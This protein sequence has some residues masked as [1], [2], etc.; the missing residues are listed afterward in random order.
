[1]D[2]V[3][4]EDLLRRPFLV[5]HLSV[6]VSLSAVASFVADVFDCT[7][8]FE[9][10]FYGSAAR[11]HEGA[12]SMLATTRLGV[13]LSLAGWPRD[14]RAFY[15][16]A[17]DERDER[18]IDTFVGGLP[19]G[20][21]KHTWRSELARYTPPREEDEAWVY[22]LAGL[23]SS[24]PDVAPREDASRA[25]AAMLSARGFGAWYVPTES[26]L[27]AEPHPPSSR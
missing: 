26:E 2:R 12:Q 27:R 3:H 10:R 14:F 6:D 21:G 24:M 23:P 13:E 5:R 16:L 8:D 9:P 1:M 11:E 18:V 4:D 19:R 15:G 7:F 22:Q 20:I 17:R 25:I